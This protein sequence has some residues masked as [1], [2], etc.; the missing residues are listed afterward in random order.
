MTLPTVSLAA[1][2]RRLSASKPRI[3]CPSGSAGQA[4]RNPGW[5]QRRVRGLCQNAAGNQSCKPRRVAVDAAAGRRG[6]TGTMTERI[7]G[8]AAGLQVI[9]VSVT[10][11]P[12]QALDR[13]DLAIRP[14][15]LFVLLGGSGSG[16]STLLRAI[17]GL[18]RPGAGQILLDGMD[19][20]PLPP[21][22]RPVNT[23]FQ[24]YA[25][26]PHMSVAANIGFG[27]RQQGLSRTS[28]AARVQKMLAMVRLEGFGDRR[29][30]QLSGGQQQ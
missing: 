15:E 30:Q 12:V 4:G 23:M 16:K 28:V 7:P 29:P 19:L 6:K 27:L 21:H 18:V 25:L 17:A 1:S 24:S 22:R 20:A 13:L 26:F 11:V 8:A 10:Y 2:I 3:R 5:S 14:G 9:G